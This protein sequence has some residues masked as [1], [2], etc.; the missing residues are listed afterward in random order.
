[1][2]QLSRA[3]AVIE[4]LELLLPPSPPPP[5]PD[6]TIAALR[7]YAAEV[8]RRLGLGADLDGYD[9]D[10]ERARDAEMAMLAMSM[11][12]DCEAQVKRHLDGLDLPG[13]EVQPWVR[14]ELALLPAARRGLVG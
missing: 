9:T 1:M 3:L 4:Q 13:H 6:M 10:L 11:A 5:K 14:D 8:W 7:G 2:S 12:S